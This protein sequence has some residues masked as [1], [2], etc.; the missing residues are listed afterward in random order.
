[1]RLIERITRLFRADVHDL[2]DRIEEPAVVLRQ[3]VRD[4]EKELGLDEQSIRQ[5]ARDDERLAN[6]LAESES[7]LKDIEA[8]L[9]VCFQS[10][11]E[12]LA[13]R[14]IKRRLETQN[15]QKQLG[16]K[17]SQMKDQLARR[18]A[19][20][21][22]NQARLEEIRQKAELL[23][24]EASDETLGQEPGFPSDVI[25]DEDVEVAFLREKQI[26]SRP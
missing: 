24:D 26:R 2:L 5:L 1:M 22:E 8:R 19:R 20:F 13:R 14:L 10:G 4:M 7:L 21:E 6:R 18:K 11:R 15:L 23:A 9:D 25:R 3:A 16:R 12:E 17:R